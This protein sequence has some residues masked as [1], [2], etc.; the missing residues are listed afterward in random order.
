M[1]DKIDYTKP[2]KI[3]IMHKGERVVY[4]DLEGFDHIGIIKEVFKCS[5]DLEPVHLVGRLI[6]VPKRAIVSGL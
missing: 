6:Q 2:V 4:R 1:E 5:V 3:P